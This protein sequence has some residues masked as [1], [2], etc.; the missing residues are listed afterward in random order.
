MTLFDE[1]VLPAEMLLSLERQ[2]HAESLQMVNWG[3]FEG[4]H[5]VEFAPT[6]TLLSGGSGTGKST[7]LDAY[8]AL[9]MDSNVPFNGASNDSATGRARSADQRNVLSYVRGKVDM[10]REAG[11]GQLKDEVLRGRDTSAWS[12][13]AMTWRNDLNE[14]FT[15]FR[16]YFAPVSAT[17]SSEITMQMGTMPRSFDLS[18]LEQ[19][20]AERFPRQR[21]SSQFD[22][23]AFYDSYRTFAATIHTRLGIGT[24]GDG[25]RALKL[26][27]RIQGGRQVTTVDDLYKTMV[28]EEPRTFVVADRAINHFDDLQASYDTMRNAEAQVKVLNDI[29]D[30][31][32]SLR[33]AEEEIALVDTYRVQS[34]EV[35]TPFRLW[36]NRRESTL[37]DAAVERNR[38]LFRNATDRF[39]Q[40]KRDE[41]S[42]KSEIADT[43]Q[44]QRANGGDALDSLEHALELLRQDQKDVIAA[45]TMFN[46]RIEVLNRDVSDQDQFNTLRRE[47]E[48]FIA[49]FTDRETQL[50]EEGTLIGGRA[51]PLQ[52][53]KDELKR[54]F[55]SLRGRQ[56]LVPHDLH[57]A[58]LA[59]AEAIGVEPREVPF[60][61]EM[62]D[63]DPRYEDWR[64]A[65]ELALGGFALTM[66]VDQARL[67]HVRRNINSIQMK[68]RLQFEGADLTH[69]IEYH[70]SLDVLPGRFQTKET[71][72]TGWLMRRLTER[73]NFTCVDR[74]DQ[75]DATPLG[76][77]VTG[78]TRQG[79]RGAHGGYGT[80]RVIGFSNAS[81]LVEIEHELESLQAQLIDLAKERQL[82]TGRRQALLQTRDAHRHVFDASWIN[83][84]VDTIAAAI[85][86]KAVARTR[87]LEASDLLTQLKDEEQRL[88]AKLED[89]QF[90]TRKAHEQRDELT[91]EHGDLVSRQDEIADRIREMENRDNLELS[92]SQRERLEAEF[93]RI[94]PNPQLS[95]FDKAIADL[96]A[97]LGEQSLQA[98]KEADYAAKSLRI[99]FERFQDQWAQPNLGVEVDSYQGYKEI[100]DEL[101]AEG[102]YQ[103][104]EKW[105]QQVNE[106]SGVDL[107]A[108]NGAYND[109]IEEIETRLEPV[110]EILSRLPFGAGRDRLHITLRR[111]EGKDIGQ[112]RK[113]LKT[114]SS[115]TTD[116][117][118]YDQ[119]E[120]RFRRLQKFIDRIR[121]SSKSLEREYL[122]DVR[123]HVHIEA[124]RRDQAGRQLGVYTSLGGKSGGETQELV[125]FIV[126]AALRYQ[127]GDANLR[128]P[129]YAPVFLDEGFVKSDSEFAGRAVSAWQGLG[130]QLIIGA[131]NDKVTAIEP[132]MDLLLQ[133][134]KN[135]KNHS[136]VSRI[137]ANTPAPAVD[138]IS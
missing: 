52:A 105:S 70:P 63:M 131:P 48:H 66:L 13:V 94:E 133:V 10:S 125:A 55:D 136:H 117:L 65:A 114:L 72:F 7:L 40:G 30:T 106:W 120:A 75:L 6:A 37:L 39:E 47:S 41:I 76:L 83:I 61:A 85:E 57:V 49:S 27:A 89:V 71:P 124:E 12:A 24:G 122:I 20:A 46:T 86:E 56:G 38:E 43:K 77:T 121:R 8:I 15:A 102:L 62:L 19:F 101:K 79:M 93:A 78:Q 127:L 18:A 17:Q 99:T 45:R 3:G 100:L 97:R 104:R 26:L 32:Q 74:P 82:I 81:R 96:K 118:D 109:S 14:R 130:F 54:E 1:A 98:R 126:G 9:M 25:A 67:P 119:A 107:L 4:H 134:T 115:G 42:I 68:R 84:D 2:W 23:V 51:Y 69:S 28:L 129:R 64:Q 50:E 44:Q 92:S 58:R 53:Q 95:G 22:G 34:P 110:N 123:R 73:F 116:I 16:V 59:V 135:S 103:R 90:R 35:H 128:R 21:M 33:D 11:T 88:T 5:T 113:E 80:P 36:S 31:Y 111:T 137:Q 132:Y 112:F 29:P 60:V 108:L 91:T 138:V 87:L